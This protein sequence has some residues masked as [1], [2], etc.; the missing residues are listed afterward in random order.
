MNGTLLIRLAGPLQSWGMNSKF[1][2]RRNTERIPT[3]SGVI[4]ILASALGRKRNVNMEDLASLKFGVRVDNGGVL[5]RDYHTAVSQKPY[6][7]NRFYLSDAVF[8]AGF[9]GPIELLNELDH[10]LNYP[11][12]PLFLGRR[13][14]PPEGRVNL[15]I[16][17]NVSL[18]GALAAEP[19]LSKRRSQND[20]P[21]FDLQV[22][23][24]DEKFESKNLQKDVPVSFSS[25]KRTYS[26][27]AVKETSIK[28]RE[29][30]TTVDEE[31]K[32]PTDHDPIIELEDI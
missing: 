24:D 5:L 31:N 19:L 18:L 1:E 3:K 29:D 26:Y 21:I 32:N 27:R 7:T 30:D 17:V 20:K 2:S 13:S 22:F 15:G 11:M 23:I 10:A 6:V 14:C 4:G 16:K 9:E 25:R 28:V 12:Y 8:L